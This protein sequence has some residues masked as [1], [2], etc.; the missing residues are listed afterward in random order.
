MEIG[1]DILATVSRLMM[2]IYQ[3]GFRFETQLGAGVKAT[4]VSELGVEPE[5]VDRRVQTVFMDGRAVDDLEKAQLRTGN[6]LTLSGAMPGLVGACFRKSGKYA[7]L[8]SEISY[9]PPDLSTSPKKGLITVKLFNALIPELGPTFLEH[10]I[11]IDRNQYDFLMKAVDESPHKSS[12]K[13][14]MIIEKWDLDL[15]RIRVSRRI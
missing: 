3:Q 5:F 8:R 10:G 15:F 11:L 6:V 12:V 2:A 1:S 7:P 4:L 14:I 13:N 9:T